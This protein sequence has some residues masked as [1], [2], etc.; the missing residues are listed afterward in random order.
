MVPTRLAGWE[1]NERSI[2][3]LSDPQAVFNDRLVVGFSDA[4]RHI[5]VVIDYV[6]DGSRCRLNSP[7]RVD[8]VNIVVFAQRESSS[9]AR[10]S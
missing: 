6:S 7:K 1:I 8:T 4:Q 2:F 9:P 3:F 5:V 10:H